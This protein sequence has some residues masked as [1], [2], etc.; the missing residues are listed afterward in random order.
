MRKE[1][2]NVPIS[3][4][5]SYDQGRGFYSSLGHNEH[6]Y[7]NPKVLQHYLAGIQWAIGDLLDHDE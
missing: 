4:A 5:K 2:K 3:W 7:Y 6:I 1:T